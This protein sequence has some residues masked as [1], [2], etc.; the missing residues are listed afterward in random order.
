M[1]ITRSALLLAVLLGAGCGSRQP[2]AARLAAVKRDVESFMRSVAEGVT[3]EGPAA[4]RNY[5]ENSPAFLM[6]ADGRLEFADGA[7][8]QAAI[9][10]LVRTFRK[11]ELQWGDGLRV[12]PL[13]EDFAAIGAP[14][15]E[16][17]TPAEGNPVDVSGYF[18]AVADRRGGRWQ[19][20][21]AHWSSIQT[22]GPAK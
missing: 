4:W 1:R 3:K 21:N 12:D 22:C 20:R 18:T 15:H 6:A 9:P 7:A 10:D 14:W 2:D 16:L 11:I 5:L 19:F 17:L 8:A 13:S